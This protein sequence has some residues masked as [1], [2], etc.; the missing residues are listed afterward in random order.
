M[1]KQP[2]RQQPRRNDN[3]SVYKF[4]CTDIL[5]TILTTIT[6]SFKSSNNAA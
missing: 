2:K 5:C 4:I 3:R 6:F 1:S